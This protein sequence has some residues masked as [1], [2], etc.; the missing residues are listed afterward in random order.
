MQTNTSLD[1]ISKKPD[2]RQKGRN[3]AT[4]DRPILQGEN[5]GGDAMNHTF[6]KH[7][8]H[9]PYLL[10]ERTTIRHGRITIHALGEGNR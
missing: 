7:L 6:T 2:I 4:I 8:R 10:E 3:E 1:K 9:V 5:A